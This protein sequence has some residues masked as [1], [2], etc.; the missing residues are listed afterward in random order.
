MASFLVP[1]YPHGVLQDSGAHQ[2]KVRGIYD[3]HVVVVTS[4]IQNA[5]RDG[6]CCGP[7]TSLTVSAEWHESRPTRDQRHAYSYTVCYQHGPSRRG[8]YGEEKRRR[9]IDAAQ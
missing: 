9:G 1:P 5:D 2:M 3:V 8:G 4:L 6:L 7:G